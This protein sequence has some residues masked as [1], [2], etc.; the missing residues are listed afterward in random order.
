M[1][2]ALSKYLRA[3]HIVAPVSPSLG[4]RVDASDCVEPP[5]NASRVVCRCRRIVGELRGD[6]GWFR[7]AAPNAVRISIPASIR[8]TIRSQKHI[9]FETT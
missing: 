9:G 1:A 8:V 2:L 6:T 4:V 5:S 3:D 7:I